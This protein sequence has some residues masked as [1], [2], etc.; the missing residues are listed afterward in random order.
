MDLGRLGYRRLKCVAYMKST[1]AAFV[2]YVTFVSRKKANS[3]LMLQVG[4]VDDE[5]VFKVNDEGDDNDNGNDFYFDVDVDDDDNDYN[6]NH[7]DGYDDSIYGYDLSSYFKPAWTGTSTFV[8]QR[9]ILSRLHLG[10]MMDKR[11]WLVNIP[12]TTLSILLRTWTD[13]I[14]KGVN[15]ISQASWILDE[16]ATSY[17]N[18]KRLRDFLAERGPSGNVKVEKIYTCP[19]VALSDALPE[20]ED[21]LSRRPSTISVPMDRTFLRVMLLEHCKANTNRHLGPKS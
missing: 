4:L 14:W 6:D 5:K 19:E 16:I 21:L 2:S 12:L 13:F 17:E 18:E 8:K 10:N 7:D 11:S 1:T 3:L 15:C 20:I 9:I